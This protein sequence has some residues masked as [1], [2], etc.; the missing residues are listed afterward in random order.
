MIKFS[1]AT[2]FD[3]A[4]LSEIGILNRKYAT[5]KVTEVYGSLPVSLTGSGRSSVGLPNVSIQDIA[6][7][8][9]QAHELGLDFNY[10]MN[11]SVSDFFYNAEWRKKLHKFILDLKEIGVN[12]ITIADEVLVKYV[13]K[14]FKDL[15]VHI[16]LIVGIDTPELARKFSDLG[17]E[18]IT[19]NQHTINRNT[20]TIKEIVKAVNCKV[21][22]Y[23]NISCLHDCQ[24]RDKHY[25]W[26]NSRSTVDSS[27]YKKQVDNFILWCEKRYMND[28]IELLKSSFIRPEGLG[29]YRKTGVDS[30]K[31]SD[32]RESTKDL[33]RLLESYMGEHYHG[34]LFSLLFRDDRKWANAV[35][36]I[37]ET[38]FLGHTA[39][40][41]DNDKL[42]DLDFDVMVTTLKG[43]DL[44]EFY[45][46][47][48]KEAV[49]G[50]LYSRTKDFHN[51]LH[52]C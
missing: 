38:K 15:P 12:S 48:T 41:I 51:K 52:S 16:S 43:N 4:F 32:R 18:L 50:I 24:M 47:A 45:Q 5:A 20:E 44:K 39:I 40:N 22:L 49:S 1:I 30:F 17:V 9:D 31:L 21:R 29:L 35:R 36:D 34:N 14:E 6:M 46:L 7:H 8:I 2:N 13:R 3:S 42:T 10:L 33:V 26:L 28:P 23:A 25:S 11:A 37:V 19:L 27:N